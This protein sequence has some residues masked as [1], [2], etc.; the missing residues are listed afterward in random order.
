MCSYFRQKL[1]TDRLESAE[2]REWPQK[3]FHDQF[4]RKNVAKPSGD[5]TCDLLNH[6]SDSPPTEAPRPAWFQGKW[7]LNIFLRFDPAF[8]P[9]LSVSLCP[10]PPPSPPFLG[11]LFLRIS[12]AWPF[13]PRL[14][15]IDGAA[16]RRYNGRPNIFWSK[17]LTIFFFFFFFFFFTLEAFCAILLLPFIINGTRT[18]K[19]PVLISPWGS[20]KKCWTAITHKYATAIERI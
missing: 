11:G 18:G 15:G 7:T 10:H 3:I 9:L 6:Q 2:D 1:T 8:F 13:E 16:L 5:R 19:L 14:I 20:F 4:P 12:Y 17:N